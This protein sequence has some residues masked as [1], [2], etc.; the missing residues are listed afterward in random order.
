MRHAMSYKTPARRGGL[1]RP[2]PLCHKGLAR[3]GPTMSRGLRDMS[4]EH[5]LGDPGKA[6]MADGGLT[7]GSARRRLPE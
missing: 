7:R 6:D 2:R 3:L 1:K 4:Y 5:F